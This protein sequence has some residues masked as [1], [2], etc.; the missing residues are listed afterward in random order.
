M[1]ILT[2]HGFLHLLGYDHS[3]RLEKEENKAHKILLL[4]SNPKKRPNTVAR[5]KFIVARPNR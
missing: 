1:E 2:V 5:R 3:A 4:V